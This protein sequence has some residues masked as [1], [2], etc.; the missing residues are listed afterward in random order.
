MTDFQA[1][2]QRLQQVRESRIQQAKIVQAGVNQGVGSTEASSVLTGK[3]GVYGQA[4]TGIANISDEEGIAN[5]IFKEQKHMLNTSIFDTLATGMNQT[6][7][8][9]GS[10]SASYNS[11]SGSSAGASDP[12]GG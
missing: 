12:N 10:L 8:A 3:S 9:L 2:Q 1:Q 4:E 5:D 7:G 11:G 6:A